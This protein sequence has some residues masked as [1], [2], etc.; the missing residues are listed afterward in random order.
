MWLSADSGSSDKILVTF[1]LDSGGTGG[2][3][4]IPVS[5]ERTMQCEHWI[6]PT[7]LSPPGPSV[8]TSHPHHSGL[9]W[10]AGRV[11]HWLEVPT[12]LEV[13]QFSNE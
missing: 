5:E 10:P 7:P 8:E 6:P 4:L 11:Q 1:S 3:T 9:Q 12:G 13:M 2:F